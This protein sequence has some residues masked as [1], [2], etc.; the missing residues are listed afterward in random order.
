MWSQNAEGFMNLARIAAVPL[1][2]ALVLVG[3]EAGAQSWPN[4]TVQWIV[5]FP[6]GGSSDAVVR[7]VAEK[8]GETSGQRIVVI[9]RA[10]AN[11]DIGAQAVA[12]SAP[13]GL[14]LMLT[15]PSIVTNPMYFKSSLDPA[16]LAPV[17][18]MSEGAYFLLASNSFSASSA[19]D[20][21]KA[22][23]S[24]PGKVR[25]ALTGGSGTLGC[26]MLRYYAKSDM[27]MVPYKG[28][29]P[30]LLAAMS[31]EVDLVFQFANTAESQV[32]AG[33]VK[34]IAGPAAKRGSL[35]FPDL[36]VI[37]EAIPEFELIG[38]H[39][40]MVPSATP[41][42]LVLRINRALNGALGSAD[43]KATFAKSGLTAVGGTPE[44]FG[45]RLKAEQER[46]GRILKAAGVQPE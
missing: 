12:S 39:G 10:G 22:I 9:N 2:A 42:E 44:A 33:K 30:G 15:L 17:I 31:G 41:R 40:V 21:L 8:L 6:A 32:K 14:T 46:Y 13:D 36:P 45:A 43:V 38:W 16:R 27:L 20:A 3:A 11:G 23:R 26:E 19:G 34:A 1:A 35:P 29:A 4:G 5:P 37:A 24:S 7:I 18:Q 25:C 28:S